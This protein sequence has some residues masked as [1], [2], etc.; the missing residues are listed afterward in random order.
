MSQRL[1]TQLRR[2][3]PCLSEHC[4]RAGVAVERA[5]RN[6]R[7]DEVYMLDV[8]FWGVV[9]VEGEGEVGWLLI[10]RQGRAMELW[11]QSVES[12]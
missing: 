1:F 4:A 9:D 5:R 3:E 2:K 8:G 6:A 11:K 10:L 7:A 12:V